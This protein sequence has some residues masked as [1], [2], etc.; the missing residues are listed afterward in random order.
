LK[1]KMKNADRKT[2]E[3]ALRILEEGSDGPGT[4]R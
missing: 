1:E 3:D 2:L 4:D